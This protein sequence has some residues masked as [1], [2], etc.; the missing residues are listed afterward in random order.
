MKKPTV[1]MR[2]TA[3]NF[4]A[5]LLNTVQQDKQ[6]CLKA[7]AVS[8]ENILYYGLPLVKNGIAEVAL[9]KLKKLLEQTIY[10]FNIPAVLTQ[11]ETSLRSK[12]ED[13]GAPGENCKRLLAEGTVTA[14]E[15]LRDQLQPL[16]HKVMQMDS[17]ILRENN[18]N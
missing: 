17:P 18:K 7:L 2:E 4:V 6:D 13:M 5:T 14:R 3:M 15:E 8:P 11:F 9:V 10:D 16:I 12:N 1:T